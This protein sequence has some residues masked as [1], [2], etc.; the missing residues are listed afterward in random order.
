MIARVHSSVAIASQIPISP[1]FKWNTKKYPNGKLIATIDKAPI[2]TGNFASP[3][4]RNEAD[5]DNIHRPARLEQN[6]KQQN[7]RTNFNDMR[8]IRK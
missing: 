7:S 6:A 8:I 3:A 4:A 2:S 5:D 1:K